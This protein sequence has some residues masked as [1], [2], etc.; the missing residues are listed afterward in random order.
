MSDGPQD[1]SPPLPADEVCRRLLTELAGTLE[2]WAAVLLIPD[3]EGRALHVAAH[4][5]LPP[6]WAAGA[7]PL[8][9]GSMNARAHRSQTE[10]VD[11]DVDDDLPP[12]N[13]GASR[14]RMTAAAVVI[15]RGVGTLEVL[16]DTHGY[17]FDDRRLDVM[18]AAAD[19]LHRL[20]VGGATGDP[21]PEAAGKR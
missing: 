15:V 6:D 21:G 7:N 14:H 18:R 16:A 1:S 5:N 4:H 10:I 13:P 20:L 9:S 19:D 3:G 11:N 8:A 12:S 2:A 17:V